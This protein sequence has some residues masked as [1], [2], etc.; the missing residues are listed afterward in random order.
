MGTL[1]RLIDLVPARLRV[2]LAGAGSA[3]ILLGALGF[4]FIGGLSPCPLCI[5]QRWPHVAGVVLAALALTVLARHAR[6]VAVLAALAVLIGAGIAVYHTGIEHHWWEGPTTCTSGAITDL[7]PEQL[8]NR[9][10]TAPLVRCDE[11]VWDF[12]GLTMA[13][14][15][16]VISLG[17]AALWLTCALRPPEP[18]DSST[19]SQ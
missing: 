2:L 19:A 8:M 1:W 5:Y 17:L 11:I 4:Q 6:P 3:A 12:L 9:I 10:M 13:S 14:W 15:N 18:Q 16:A 7:T